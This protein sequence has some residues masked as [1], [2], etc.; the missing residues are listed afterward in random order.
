MSKRETR[1]VHLSQLRCWN[2]PSL[3]KNFGSG[4]HSCPR[5]VFRDGE[6][7]PE[8]F[9]SKCSLYSETRQRETGQK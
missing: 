3:T 9:A 2:C 6:L 4:S 8:F 5:N 7:F 1:M